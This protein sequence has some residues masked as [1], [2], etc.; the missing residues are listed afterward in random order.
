M[1]VIKLLPPIL[2]G[3]A[4]ILTAVLDY[5]YRD[6]RTVAF[7]KGRRWLFGSL[8]VFLLA[9]PVSVYIDDRAQR[10]TTEHL[11]QQL[12][13]VRAQSET[14]AK[15]SSVENDRLRL[16]LQSLQA[17]TTRTALS[18]ADAEHALRIKAEEIARLNRALADLVTGGSSYGYLSLTS[19][20]SSACVLTL[21]HSGDHPLYDVTIRVVDLDVFDSVPKGAGL[22]EYLSAD[23]RY[24]VGNVSPNQALL[25]GDF[26]LGSGN[27]RS[28]NIFIAARN[29]L[30]TQVLRCRRV[31]GTWVFA[32]KGF[33]QD[34][35][36]TPLHQK[37]DPAF[38]RGPSGDVV[39]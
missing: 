28:F 19:C 29:G 32:T 6:K 39:W 12:E 23:T 21:V 20:N 35:R 22:A 11:R 5:L 3:L 1:F 17:L 36:A 10:D 9:S 31:N 7:K 37:I 26:Q 2:G 34:A 13:G 24:A 33:R 4:L 38:P 14:Q 18:Q 16:E 15:R 8:G 27:S 30:I 25:L